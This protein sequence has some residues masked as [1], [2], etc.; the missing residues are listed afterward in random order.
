[1]C[2]TF[3]TNGGWLVM[4]QIN[5]LIFHYI[6]EIVIV[7]IL[8]GVSIPLWKTFDKANIAHIANSYSNM[9]YIYLNVKRFISDTDSLDEI[10]VINDTNT[11]RNYKL[12]M[13]VDKTIKLDTVFFEEKNIDLSKNKYKEDEKYNYYLLTEN[14]LVAGFKIYNLEFNELNNGI[15]Y[16]II[17]SKNI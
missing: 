10:K 9:N 2:Y 7:I 17:E 4:K 5:K 3:N 12:V 13:K 15:T 14:T 8:V 16:E 11:L 6:C 1:M